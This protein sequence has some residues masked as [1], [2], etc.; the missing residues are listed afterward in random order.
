MD[1]LVRTKFNDYLGDRTAEKFLEL[2]D[3]MIASPD[4]DPYNVY[5][6]TAVPLLQQE[7]FQEALDYLASRMPAWLLNPGIHKL[8]S[9][10]L[11]KL[12]RTSDASFEYRLAEALLEGILSTGDGSKAH[13]YYVTS[14]VDEYDVLEHLGQELQRQTLVE[15][16]ACRYDLLACKDGTQVWFDVTDPLTHF[17]KMLEAAKEE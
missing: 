4:Y 3:T 1:E 7:K 10:A 2:R 11:H 17:E 8:A 14:V 6:D 16:D 12:G 15:K 5:R 9:F 13:P